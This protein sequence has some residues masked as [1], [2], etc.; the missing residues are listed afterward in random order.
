VIVLAV[1]TSHPAGSV[2]LARAGTVLGHVTFEQP[3]SHLVALAT[4]VERMLKAAGLSPR[5]VNRVAVVV[6]PG[7][8]TGLR[9]GL[10]FAKGLHAATGVDIV[11]IDSLRLL[12]LP[13]L[14][15]HDSVCAR[16]DARRGEVY[17]AVYDGDA[18]VVSPCACAPEALI[19][20]LQE[21]GVTPLLLVGSGV[22][23]AEAALRG[24]FPDASIAPAA[25]AQ[26]ST[27][28]LAV[29]APGLEPLD[30]SAIRQL[31][32]RY[33]R[34]SGAERVR[35]RGHRRSEDAHE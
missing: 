34:P 29:L 24:S 12:A 1:D 3:D 2:A 22:R 5:D 16:I 8:F 23:A 17:A 33:V 25:A 32:P 6:G 13:F 14:E 20:H 19:R 4:S 11:P 15:Q 9:I 10:S 35:L 28:R 18:E 30:E 31:E 27:Q 7:S 26:P 21:R